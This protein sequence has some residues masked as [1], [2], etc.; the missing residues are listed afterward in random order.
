MNL[1]E[2][3]DKISMVCQSLSGLRDF[4][5]LVCALERVPLPSFALALNGAQ[6]WHQVDFVNGETCNILCQ[7]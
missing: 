5:R 6:P 4:G 7:E 1:F 3:A 2:I